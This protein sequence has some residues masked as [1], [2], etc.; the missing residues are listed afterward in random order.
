MS[1]VPIREPQPEF[2][3]QPSDPKWLLEA[4]RMHGHLGPWAV[5]GLR[6]GQAVLADLDCKGYFD[7]RIEV[8]G[9][10]AKPPPRCIIDGLQFSTGATMGKDTIHIELADEFE[11]R[12]THTHTGR[13]VRY[14]LR[15][16]FLAAV[17]D[18]SG[19]DQVEALARRVARE[20]FE[21]LAVRKD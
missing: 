16:S 1:D 19:R 11:I 14:R 9:P 6:L 18:L 17:S 15:E 21:A 13:R 12:A 10:I 5:V 4:V 8:A 20:P 7:V 3:P 2:Q